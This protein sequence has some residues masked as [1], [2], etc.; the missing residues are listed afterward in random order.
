MEYDNFVDGITPKAMDSL[1]L[2]LAFD[3]AAHATALDI[4]AFLKQDER[5]A[6][7]L[8]AKVAAYRDVTLTHLLSHHG[9]QS[10]DTN[11][12][13]W[14]PSL[15]IP[16]SA[17][18][19]DYWI[20]PAPDD[21]RYGLDWTSPASA[22]ANRASRNDGTLFSF[23]QLDNQN[24]RSA[25]SSESG[26]GIFYQPP[27]TLGVID[28]QPHV[29]CS[30]T[31]RTLL[32]F[33]PELAAGYVEVKAQLLLAAWQQIPGGFD[34]LGFRQFDVAS[35]GRRDQT[36]GPE[37]RPFMTSFSGPSLSAPFVVQRGRTYLLG[38]VN[39]V[40]VISTLTSNTGKPL[41]AISNTLLR[42]WGSMNCVVPQIDVV[43]KRIDIP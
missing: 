35:S 41:P 36:F 5:P 23:S 16:K 32:E 10:F 20:S 39:R 15:Y 8:D 31:L 6:A 21:H 9:K 27:M 14:P 4:D 26:L 43:T 3:E 11:L 29:D 42:V 19:S 38:V 24:A 33:F 13:R 34:L 28:F 18:A 2:P 25:Q 37:L 7:A 40:S 12:F 17:K 1:R 30:G 22:T